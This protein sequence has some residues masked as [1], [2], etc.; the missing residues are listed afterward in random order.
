[1]KPYTENIKGLNGGGEAYDLPLSHEIRKTGMIG[2]VKPG[3]TQ[4]LCVVQ[5]EEFSITCYI[6]EMYI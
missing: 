3:L 2:S 1:V 5:T 6:R 4:E